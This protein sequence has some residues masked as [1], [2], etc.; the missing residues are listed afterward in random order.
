[1]NIFEQ[2]EAMHQQVREFVEKE[3]LGFKVM[4][5][6]ADSTTQYFPPMHALGENPEYILL[7]CIPRFRVQCRNQIGSRLDCEV[8]VRKDGALKIGN[9]S[10]ST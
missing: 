3:Y 9:M 8:L 10:A 2:V 4:S 6:M 1:M 7:G 5:V